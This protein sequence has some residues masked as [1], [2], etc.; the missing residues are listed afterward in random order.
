MKSDDTTR[1]AHQSETA[2]SSRKARPAQKSNQTNGSTRSAHQSEPTASSQDA[3]PAQESNQTNA[4]DKKK[5]TPDEAAKF[6]A[7]FGTANQ[8]LLAG[9]FHQ[10]DSVFLSNGAVDE[11]QRL[12]FT[13]SI[14]GGTKSRA[15]TQIMLATEVAA[16]HSLTMEFAQRLATAKSTT[17]IEIIGNMFNKLARTSATLMEVQ[18]RFPPW[19][20]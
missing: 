1:S 13:A 19:R 12:N 18:Q 3:R 16:V 9:I 11:E 7:A 4:T 14:I 8:D 17:E 10:L 5:L 20:E 6:W 2:A 15:P